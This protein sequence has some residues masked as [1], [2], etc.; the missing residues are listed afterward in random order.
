MYSHSPWISRRSRIAAMISSTPVTSAQAA[1]TYSRASVVTSGQTKVTMPVS[2]PTTPSKMSH[3][4]R[5]R[6]SPVAA[7]T[8][9]S[10]P[11]TRA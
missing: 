5:P 1:I 3:P 2:T 6:F 4:R 11:S 7:A 10:T 8:R 9:A